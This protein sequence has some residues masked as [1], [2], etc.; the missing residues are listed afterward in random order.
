MNTDRKNYSTY[1]DGLPVVDLTPRKVGQISRG[2]CVKA[3]LVNGNKI[4]IRIRIK[5]ARKLTLA[6]ENAKLKKE[7]TKLRKGQTDA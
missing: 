7:I 1:K 4:K 3:T 2:M 6:Q 5:P